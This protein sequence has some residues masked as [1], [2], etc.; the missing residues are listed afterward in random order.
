MRAEWQL[1]AHENT[2][3][4]PTTC[5][6]VVEAAL[7][8]PAQQAQVGGYG[9]NPKVRRSDIR[10]LQPL[11]NPEHQDFAALWAFV[12]RR[13][14]T[15]NRNAFGVD[16]TFMHSM[17][18]TTY[19]ADEEGFFD[20]HMD[21]FYSEHART[22]TYCLHRKLSMI[23]QLSAPDSY[24]GGDVEIKA[25]PAPDPAELRKQG[26]MIVFPSFTQ[27][28]VTPVTRGVRHSLVAWMEGP[29]WR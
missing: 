7:K 26:A 3:L 21:T 29:Y 22:R 25:T 12:E 13:L 23:L 1:W 17:Q 9:Y 15:A 10:W 11:D 28:R 8:F 20:W 24:E 19:R 27:H 18:F 14:Q 2:I 6:E 16:C 4:D 5:A